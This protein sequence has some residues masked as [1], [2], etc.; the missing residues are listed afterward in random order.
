M[1]VVFCYTILVQPSSILRFPLNKVVLGTFVTGLVQRNFLWFIMY[2]IMVV[3]I[4]FV[5]VWGLLFYDGFAM[6]RKGHRI[7][8]AI[9]IQGY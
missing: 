5:G 1:M 4:V 7:A 2:G 8:A 9:Y 6:R 3:E